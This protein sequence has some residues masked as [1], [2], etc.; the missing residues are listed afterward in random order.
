MRG[1]VQRMLLFSR[2]IAKQLVDTTSAL[3]ERVQ[4]L[5]EK[6]AELRARLDGERDLR[7]LT[8][9]IA[10]AVQAAPMI[11]A[12]IER[13]S[14]TMRAPRPRGRRTRARFHGVALLRWHLYA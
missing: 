14:E 8:A 12:A 6:H 2:H 4:R 9:H 13:F 11:G 7:V 5:E 10:A 1:T 3:F